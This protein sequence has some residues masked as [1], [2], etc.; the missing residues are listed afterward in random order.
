MTYEATIQDF[1]GP[2]SDKEAAMSYDDYREALERRHEQGVSLPQEI[3]ATAIF[4]AGVI[5][6]IMF[7]LCN[8]VL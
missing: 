4:T 6:A 8:F 5:G 3:V 2:C 1:S 7:V